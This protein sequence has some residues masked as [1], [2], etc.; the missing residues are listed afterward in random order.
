M[1]ELQKRDRGVGYGER[2][3]ERE[4][5]GVKKIPKPRR[6]LKVLW[7]VSVVMK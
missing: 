5:D 3:G 7:H 2:E 4:K 1:K 6:V